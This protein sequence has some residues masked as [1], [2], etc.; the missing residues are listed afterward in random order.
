MN[1][2]YGSAGEN[3]FEKERGSKRKRSCGKDYRGKTVTDVTHSRRTAASYLY[4]DSLKQ[5]VEHTGPHNSL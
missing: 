1:F 2:P 3:S 5:T 4:T